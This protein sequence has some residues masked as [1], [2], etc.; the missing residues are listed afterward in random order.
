MRIL[1]NIFAIFASV[2]LAPLYV[3]LLV[4]F[5]YFPFLKFFFIIIIKTRSNSL[6]TPKMF[7]TFIIFNNGWW[8]ELRVKDYVM[9]NIN[10]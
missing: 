10:N 7:K 4:L 9:L 8:R 6:Y 2:P 1:Y 3:V 5:Y